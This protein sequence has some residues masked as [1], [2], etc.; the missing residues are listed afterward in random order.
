MKPI[1]SVICVTYN[2]GQYVSQTLDGFLMQETNFPFEILIHDDA[3]TDDTARII[4]K[5]IKNNKNK[6]A[7][8]KPIF[9]SENQY[10]KGTYDFINDLFISAEGTYIAYC[11]GDDYWTD[12]H[13]LQKQ[14]NYMLSHPDLGLC[15]HR[16]QAIFQDSNKKAYTVPS[17]DE[18][19]GFTTKELIRRNFIQINSVLYRTQTYN[20]MPNNIM[21][22]DWYLHLYHAQ[23]GGIGFIDEVMGVYRINQG[24]VWH[25]SYER[26]DEIWKKFGVRWLGL[27]VEVYKI[28]KDNPDYKEI[29]EGAIITSFNT[30]ARIDKQYNK[31]LST[32]AL[33]SFPEY[34]ELYIED[35]R[36]QAEQ[37]GAHSNEQA[38]IIEHYVKLNKN[39]EAENEYLGKHP[40]MK[41]GSTIKRR[42]RRLTK[43][44][45]KKG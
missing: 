29:V 8:F 17:S 31:K 32:E 12:P 13:K 14:V 4:K 21:P 25:D 45:G 39:L 10:S 5:Y 9:E 27:Y 36:K 11:E 42:L 20:N 40:I 7:V 15:F 33:R 1:V 26:I 43:I 28:Y 30:L 3:S 18:S 41:L 16:V 37:L 23:F 19:S 22:Q 24:G 34:A 6:N 38:K 35:L 44:E 2:Q